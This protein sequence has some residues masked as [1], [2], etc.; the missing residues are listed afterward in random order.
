MALFYRG[1]GAGT[2]WQRNDART[3]GFVPQLPGATPSLDRLMSHIVTGTTASPYISL[4]RS[5]GVAQNY[6]VYVGTV[7]PT[8]A[9]PA[10]VYE[11]EFSGRLPR[12]LQL[13]D[14]IKE[15]AGALREPPRADYHHDGEQTFLLGV[16]DPTNMATYRTAPYLQPPPGGGTPRAPRLSVQFESLVRVLRD[17]EVLA[18]GNIPASSITRRIEVW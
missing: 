17:A 8:A 7:R 6:A 10:V 5:Y 1:A 4:T 15:V 2:Y 11:L 16:V 18:V 3:T 14:P 12:G 13:I 9:N